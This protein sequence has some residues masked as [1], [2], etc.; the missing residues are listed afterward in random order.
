MSNRFKKAIIDDVTS[1]NIDE[2]LQFHLL[3]FFE[4]AM[5]SIA[6]TLAREARFNTTDF[7]TAKERGCES[8]ALTVSRGRTDSR[9]EWFGTFTRGDQRLEVLGHLE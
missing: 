3:D 6:T 7:A 4:H 5:K 1:A 9:T 8:F 2:G